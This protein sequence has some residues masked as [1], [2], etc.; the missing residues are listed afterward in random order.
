MVVLIMEEPYLLFSYT[1][2]CHITCSDYIIMGPRIQ[3]VAY[4]FRR[5]VSPI[6]CMESFMLSLKKMDL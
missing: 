5:F 1:P 3:V 2:I 6:M 4:K